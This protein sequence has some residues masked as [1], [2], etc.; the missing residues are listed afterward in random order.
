MKN[1]TKRLNLWIDEDFESDIE[2]LKKYLQCRIATD[3]GKVSSS[4]AIRYAIKEYASVCR[5]LEDRLGIKS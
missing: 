3:C 4:D 1:Y 2:F 5:D